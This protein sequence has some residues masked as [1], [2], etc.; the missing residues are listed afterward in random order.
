MQNQLTDINV[1]VIFKYFITDN[2]FSKIKGNSPS[3]RPC[4]EKCHADSTLALKRET[5]TINAPLIKHILWSS[6]S[7]IFWD[8]FQRLFL[9]EFLHKLSQKVSFELPCAME[10]SGELMFLWRHWELSRN[11]NL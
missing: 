5:V 9:N 7:Q 1:F 3:T 6:R 2:V 11:L 8:E 4:E 10:F